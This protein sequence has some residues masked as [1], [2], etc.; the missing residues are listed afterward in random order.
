MAIVDGLIWGPFCAQVSP[1]RRLESEARDH[2]R[3]DHAMEHRATGYH[4][5]A[6]PTKGENWVALCLSDP[7]PNAPLADGV[8]L[9]AERSV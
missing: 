8:A 1:V 6:A 2:R 5:S 3:S 4:A 7:L 9:T